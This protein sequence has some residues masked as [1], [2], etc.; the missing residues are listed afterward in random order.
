MLTFEEGTIQIV[1]PQGWFKPAN[2]SLRARA[3]GL[4]LIY[5]LDL[6]IRR[7]DAR[8]VRACSSP[9]ECVAYSADSRVGNLVK[10][11]PVIVH[12]FNMKYVYTYINYPIQF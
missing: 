8:P 3:R 10:L 9:H 11:F 1:S 7:R 2:D 4:R 6:N 5:L 12:I